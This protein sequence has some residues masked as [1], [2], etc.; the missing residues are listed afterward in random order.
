MPTS[1]VKGTLVKLS[2]GVVGMFAFAIF[3]MPPLYYVLCDL[4]G[5]GGKTCLLYTSD[6]ADE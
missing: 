3:I 6:A 5:I 2:V 1:P 4:T